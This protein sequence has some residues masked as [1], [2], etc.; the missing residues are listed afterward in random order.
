M[1]N[2]P[3]EYKDPGTPQAAQESERPLHAGRHRTAVGVHGRAEQRSD[4]RRRPDRARHLGLHRL[5]PALRAPERN[6]ATAALARDRAAKASE[7]SPLPDSKTSPGA[8]SPIPAGSS[9]S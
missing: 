4:L 9:I 5:P 8:V 7:D 6:P 2:S 1:C 3:S